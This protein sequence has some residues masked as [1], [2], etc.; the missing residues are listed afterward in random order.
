MKRGTTDE[1]VLARIDG[2][3]DWKLLGRS[4]RCG[5]FL[6]LDARAV[7]TGHLRLVATPAPAKQVAVDEIE[8]YPAENLASGK[9]YELSPAHPEKY[10]DPDRKRLT[11]GQVSERGFGDGR[12]GGWYFRNVEVSLD[13]GQIATIDAVRVH[14]QGGGYGAV[15][16][17][18]RIDVLASSDGRSWSWVGAID[19]PSEKLLV[20][21]AVEH[22]R[23]QLGWMCARLQSVAAQFVMLR[24]AASS[25][26]MISEIEVLASGKNVAAGRPYHLRPAPASSA[27]YADTSGKLTDGQ[28]G[29]AGFGRAVGWNTDQPK[30]VVD[31]GLPV[32][33]SEV[34]AH[35][36]GGGP[37]GVYFPKKMTVSTSVDGMHWEPDQATTE[38]PPEKGHQSAVGTL[39]VRCFSRPCRYVRLEFQRHGWLML[40]EVEVYGPGHPN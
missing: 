3:S 35:V 17:P 15:H 31:L 33:V 23:L 28:Y 7:F 19:R 21:R 22:A 14:S 9:P 26:T 5:S 36:V 24:G 27:P 18:Q 1:H 30:V 25:W 2:S 29:T 34:A 8:I 20:D 13:L 40:D 32:A 37:G 4:V 12:T 39:R 10:G 6:D 16:F 11:D 38:R